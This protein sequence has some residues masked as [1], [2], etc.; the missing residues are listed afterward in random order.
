MGQRSYRTVVGL[1][2]GVACALSWA[3]QSP[4]VYSYF[5][6]KR[7]LT[8][9]RELVAIYRAPELGRPK[10]D[11]S[12]LQDRVLHAGPIAGWWLLEIPGGGTRDVLRS[13]AAKTNGVVSPVFYDKAGKHLLFQPSIIVQFNKG[14]SDETAQDILSGISNGSFKR[15]FI[16]GQYRLDLPVTTGYDVLDKANELADNPYIKFAVPPATFSG[17]RSYTP[18][19]PY[20]EHQ[21]ALS[22]ATAFPSGWGPRLSMR[23]TRA[24][25]V[26]TATSSIGIL[27]IDDGVQPDHPDLPVANGKGFLPLNVNGVITYGTGNPLT[28]FDNHGTAMA[29]VIGA[30]MDNGKGIAGVASGA[31][32]LTARAHQGGPGATMTTQDTAVSNALTWGYANGARVSNNSNSYD[33]ESPIIDQAYEF[34]KLSGI[35][36]FCASGNNGGTTVEYPAAL[37]TVN[38]VTGIFPNG[39]HAGGST[40]ADIDFSAPGYYSISTDRTTLPIGYQGDF[41]EI[42]SGDGNYVL[43]GSTFHGTSFASAYGAGVA[44]LLQTQHPDWLPAQIELA[45][46][47]TAL[48]LVE[49]PGTTPDRVGWDDRWGWGLIDA[50]AAVS[51]EI[52]NSVT[53]NPNPVKGGLKVAI[54]LGLSAPAPNDQLYKL[55]SGNNFVIPID[56]SNPNNHTILIPRDGVNGQKSFETRGV[57]ASTP[58]KVYVDYINLRREVTVNVIPAT[59]NNLLLNR[60]EV[61]GGDSLIGTIVLAGK[62]GPSGAATTVTDNS[63]AVNDVGIVTVAAQADRRNFTITTN[64]TATNTTATISASLRGFTVS[65]TLLVKAVPTDVLS[66]TL[67]RN[68]IMGGE[69]V[70]GTVILTAPA[71][72]GGAVI[73]LADDNTATSFFPTLTI[74]AGSTSGVFTIY[75]GPVGT[76]TSST[77]NATYFGK[78]KTTNLT[79]TPTL[80]ATSLT[81]TPSVVR[82]GFDATGRVE[83]YSPAPAGGVVVTLSKTNS[84]CTVPATVTIPQGLRWATFTIK[85]FVPGANPIVEG[86]I[87]AKAGGVTK[88]APITVFR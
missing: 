87:R 9:N 71:P 40:G 1:F 12:L 8:L 73:N 32:I 7:P 42:L 75:T 19:D 55:R 56:E 10:L 26:I 48:D 47:Q 70:D 68:V 6:E 24:W 78:G 31:S 88:V 15:E 65:K 43:F 85:T 84:Y 41:G 54:R 59:L 86:E 74:P 79:L 2:G 45:L 66:L 27:I 81:V 61:F 28:E 37:E 13:L 33:F 11:A 39:A 18:N 62:A 57:D 49:P 64:R 38:A 82:G 29:G 46:Q 44:A 4:E 23:V 69:R 22:S 20:F 72:T 34:T 35:V 3:G 63:A 14:V 30:T 36:H 17:R 51:T 52:L 25:D 58:V 16:P 50:F 76:T 5:K 80:W 53:A 67:A 77:I 21:W 83:I 60:T